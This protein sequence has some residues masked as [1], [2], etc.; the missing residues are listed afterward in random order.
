MGPREKFG[1]P[2]NWA[3]VTRSVVRWLGANGKPFLMT[4]A[5]ASIAFF[6]LM[7]L[8]LR[9]YQSEGF[10]RA[11]RSLAEFN[12]QRSSFEDKGNFLRYLR[13]NKLTDT[14]NAAY[15]LE[16][17]GP[18]L[19]LKR[20]K[21]VLPY[22]KEDLKLLADLK[23]PLD[24]SILGFSISLPGASP[25]DAAARVK[26]MGDYLKDTMLRQDLLEN[27]HQRAGDVRAEKQKLDNKLIAKRVELDEATRK[28]NA[29]K[30]IAAKYPEAS[31]YEARQLLSSDTDGSRYLSPVMQL[32]GVESKIADIRNDLVSLERDAAQND[33][34]LKFYAGAEK[35]NP[36]VKSGRELFEGFKALRAETF[37]DVRLDDDRTREVVN[38][39]DLLVETLQTKDLLNTRF[40]S[41][42]SVPDRRAGPGNA[43]IVIF[44]LVFGGFFAAVVVAL[45]GWMLARKGKRSIGG[46]SE[47]SVQ[48]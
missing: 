7:S 20:V 47:P 46:L 35:L 4:M 45:L 19:M 40:V 21:V 12:V 34:R 6:V 18:N 23:G 36:S 31:K 42:P 13:A 48:V 33:L 32:V 26:L 25:D 24:S 44:S 39:I 38:K 29:L 28:L 9:H 10:L 8:V 43:M 5:L 16:A 41:G 15:L 30:E 3:E 17:I 1:Q 22:T 11:S 2:V 37:K 14:P 27:I